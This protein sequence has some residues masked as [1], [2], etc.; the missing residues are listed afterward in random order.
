MKV[1]VPVKRVVDYNVK[2]RVKSDGTGVDIAN[3][4][5]S[6]NPFDEIAVEEAVRLKEKG[7][8][9]EVIAVSCGDAKC[10][11]TLR[12][13][14]AIGADRGILV[15]TTEELQPL[16]VAKLLKA[17]VD[18]EQPSLIILGKQA[19]DDDANQ[20]GQMLAALADLPQATFA[21][22]VEVAGDKA[23]VTREVDGGLET[24]SLSLPAVITTDL[25]LNEPR[26][27]TL[28]NI[29]KAKKKT[30]DIFKPED[31]GVDVKPRLK[32][33]KVAE[34]PKRGAGIK[35]PDVATLVDKLKNEAK[36]I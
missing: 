4:K 30:L 2:V 12:T 27:V 17:L 26:Y 31:L 1:L 25:R 6:M 3:V 35:V 24:I 36:V 10:Q 7:V 22:K 13:A 18:K 9:T 5:M 14:M 21:S 32:T 8:V 34:P 20:T 28:P 23:T 11:E 16:A 15:E 29:M 33:L 19:I